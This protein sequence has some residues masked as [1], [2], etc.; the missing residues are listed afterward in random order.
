MVNI[1]VATSLKRVGWGM[2]VTTFV[3]LLVIVALLLAA[4]GTV[5]SWITRSLMTFTS[6][7][8]GTEFTG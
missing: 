3:A 2:V 1:G 6:V 8:T 7:G 4:D 5:F